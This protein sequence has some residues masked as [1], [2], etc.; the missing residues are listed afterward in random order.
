MRGIAQGFALRHC[1]EFQDFF[2]E[3]FRVLEP[4]GAVALLDM[5]YPV[6]GVFAKPY[7]WYFRAVLPRLAALLGGERGA[8]E[9]MVQSVRNLP[10]EEVLCERLRRAGFTEVVSRPGIFGAVRLLT[11]RRP[12]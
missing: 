12:L 2:E 10:S 3:L 9:M 11:A 7:R 6:G 5:R 8:Y 1:R 4:G